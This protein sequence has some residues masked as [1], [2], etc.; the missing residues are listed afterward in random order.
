VEAA[1]VEAERVE[2]ES[3]E[4]ARVEAER[5]EA[6]RQATTTPV[7][8][9]QAQDGG[10]VAGTSGAALAGSGAVIIST[11]TQ[12]QTQAQ[13]NVG[14]EVDDATAT[15]AATIPETEAELVKPLT[16]EEIAIAVRNA[17]PVGVSSL[18]RT[19]YVAPKYPRVARRQNLSGWV[20]V[21]FTV[22]MDGTVKDVE[23][24]KS[25]PDGTFVNAAMRAVENWEFEPVIENETIVEK[26]A[27]VRLIF[28]LE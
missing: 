17:A 18:D 23:A 5:M 8:G 22:A 10:T 24:P 11:Q 15:D 26:R 21:T 28:A 13:S 2:A 19:R 25:E 27:G 3:V 20:D 16:A 4:V 1:R 12:A 9:E 6:E 14:L 7:E